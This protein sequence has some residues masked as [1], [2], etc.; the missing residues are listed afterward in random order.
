MTEKRTAKVQYKV[1]SDTHFWHRH[2]ALYVPDRARAFGFKIRDAPMGYT[3]KQIKEYGDAWTRT[4]EWEA[5]LA[6][7]SNHM[8]DILVDQSTDDDVLYF[9]GDLSFQF[10][11]YKDWL[12]ERLSDV[13]G[14][15]RW[16]LGN[17]D[18]VLDKYGEVRPTAQK[19]VDNFAFVGQADYKQYHGKHVFFSHYP[20]H[21][22]AADKS[23]LVS[24]HGHTHGSID[25]PVGRIDVGVD[26]LYGLSNNYPELV[27]GKISNYSFEPISLRTAMELAEMELPAAY[28]A[29]EGEITF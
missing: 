11:T 10:G 17:H 13:K 22:P 28:D 1:I 16:I 14:E 21:I 6:H 26:S 3:S 12:A 25:N 9:L 23:R 15:M 18:S 24:I 2:I 5:S 20:L 7:M 4:P 8:M 29:R 27:D 19:V